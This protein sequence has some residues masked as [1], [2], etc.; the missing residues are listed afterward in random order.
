LNSHDVAFY[1][2]ASVDRAFRLAPALDIPD[3]QPNNGHIQFRKYLDD[4]WPKSNSNVVE[5]VIILDN[6]SNHIYYY[7]IIGFFK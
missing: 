6:C 4:F 7:G 1:I 3:V 2:K 5:D